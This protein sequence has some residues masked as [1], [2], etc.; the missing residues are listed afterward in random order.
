MTNIEPQ[1]GVI[2][3][4]EKIEASVLNNHITPSYRRLQGFGISISNGF[5]IDE[6]QTPGL[7]QLYSIHFRFSLLIKLQFILLSSDIAIGSYE[8]D[9]V[10]VLRT[11]PSISLTASTTFELP[12][13]NNIALLPRT[14]RKFRI[15][16]CLKMDRLSGEP[17]T[18]IGN[19]PCIN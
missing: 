2:N 5:D 10:V 8:S 16:S 19:K 14:Q 11:R 9:Q 18:I 1:S 13:G 4:N 12:N 15:K 17:S 7:L 6:N 3:W